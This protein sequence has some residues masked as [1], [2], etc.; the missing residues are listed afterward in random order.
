MAEISQDRSHFRLGDWMRKYLTRF[1]LLFALLIPGVSLPTRADGSGV[2]RV[3]TYNIHHG[4]DPRGHLD[5]KDTAEVIRRA[6]AE[7]VALQEV[8]RRWGPRSMFRD[9]AAR[10]ALMLDMQYIFGATRDWRPRAPGRGEFGLVI[11]SRFP[12]VAADFRLLPGELEQRGVLLAWVEEDQKRFPVACIHLGLS[13]S[14]RLRQAMAA[15]SWLPVRPDLILLGD[16]NTGPQ[17]SE[18]AG[19]HQRLRDL[20]EA[21][22][23][24]QVG[25]FVYRGQPVRIDYAFAGTAWRPL[26]CR[27]LIAAASDHYPLLVELSPDY[28]VAENAATIPPEP[29]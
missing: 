12:I 24:G 13:A 19:L 6:G 22:G 4:A 28:G 27:V 25:T 26:S 15:L 21:C 10:L 14:D 23:L 3:M 2:L 11:L 5:L 20:Q 8:D 18:L 7:V 17:A 29:D 1:C 16:L 9:Q